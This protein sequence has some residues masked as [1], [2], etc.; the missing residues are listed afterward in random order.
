MIDEIQDLPVGVIGFEISGKLRADEYRNTIGPAV[1]KAAADGEVRVVIVIPNFAG[2]SRG[3]L[4]QDLRTGVEHWRA[5]K[6]LALV[7]DVGWMKHGMT[8]FGWMTPGEARHFSLAERADA[9]AWVA[10]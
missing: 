4:W 6:R 9:I 8:W 7:T 5:W 1:R 10:G 3:A 2:V